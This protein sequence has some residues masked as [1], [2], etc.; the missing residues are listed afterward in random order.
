MN[1]PLSTDP[2]C[3]VCKKAER[4]DPEVELRPY[5][6]NGAWLCFDCMKADPAREAEAH[7][8]FAAQLDSAGPVV[9]I[10]EKSGPRRLDKHRG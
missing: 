10:G 9:L 6:P 2:R 1:T 8:Q 7:K 3:Y 4:D 5:G